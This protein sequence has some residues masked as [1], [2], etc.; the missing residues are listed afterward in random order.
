MTQIIDAYRACIL[1]GA[2]PD[3]IAF[4]ATCVF[5]VMVLAAAWVAFHHAE[6]V[7]AEN[8]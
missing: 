1:Y 6:F 2:L 7:F 5:C 4:G 8:V 3:P